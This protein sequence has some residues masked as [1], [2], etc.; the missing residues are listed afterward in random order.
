MEESAQ[1]EGSQAHAAAVS[2]A[3]VAEL[4]RRIEELEG[5]DEERFGRFGAADWVACVLVA[6]LVPALLILWFAR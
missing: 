6:L 2:N 1:V 3:R 4:H 5:P